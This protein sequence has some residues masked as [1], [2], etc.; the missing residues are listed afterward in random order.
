MSAVTRTW[1]PDGQVAPPKKRRIVFLEEQP[2]SQRVAEPVQH[3]NG[4]AG[5]RLDNHF[6]FIDVATAVD[7]IQVHLAG[8][9]L[10]VD[11]GTWRADGE[12]LDPV[13]VKVAGRQ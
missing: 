8:G 6:R 5:C 3:F 9:S 13:T 2:G 1:S 4:P 10:A 7:P 11:H 12:L